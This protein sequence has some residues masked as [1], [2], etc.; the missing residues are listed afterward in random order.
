MNS[1]RLIAKPNSADGILAL[2]TGTFVF[3]SDIRFGS[4]ATGSSQQQV[5][6]CRYA[7]ESRSKFR[8][9]ASLPTGYCR[10]MALPET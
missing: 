10:L 7:A 9:I 8:E 3:Q 4:S 5:R 2:Q 6:P 1:R